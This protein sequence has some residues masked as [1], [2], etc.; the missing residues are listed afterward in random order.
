MPSTPAI[1]LSGYTEA[2]YG[3]GPGL[4]LFEVLADGTVGDGPG[5]SAGCAKSFLPQCRRLASAGR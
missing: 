5:K 2:G 3:A 1:L 4:S